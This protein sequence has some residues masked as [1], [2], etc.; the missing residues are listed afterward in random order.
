MIIWLG[1]STPLHLDQIQDKKYYY[2]GII[3]QIVVILHR[4]TEHT[5]INFYLLSSFTPECI[6]VVYIGWWQPGIACSGPKPSVHVDRLKVGC[7]ASFSLKIT[8]PSGCVY[9]CYV[10]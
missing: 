4:I 9:R 10:V 8:F 6:F 3:D 1:F 7:I 5:E 2:S